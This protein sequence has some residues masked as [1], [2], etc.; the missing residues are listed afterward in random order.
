MLL[1]RDIMAATEIVLLAGDSP[2]LRAN[3]LMGLEDVADLPTAV[4]EGLAK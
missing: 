3:L 4:E 1:L 2:E